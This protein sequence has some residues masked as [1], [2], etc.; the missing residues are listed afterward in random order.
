MVYYTNFIE[1]RPQDAYAYNNRGYVYLNTSVLDLAQA[2]FDKAIKL[3]PNNPEYFDSRA[4]L[5]ILLQE[6]EKALE[7]VKTGLLLKPSED[8]HELLMMKKKTC[9]E[10]LKSKE[11]K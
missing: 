7:D 2:D 11:V 3:C 1:K 6:Y 9:E 8:L 10:M 5:F 4:E